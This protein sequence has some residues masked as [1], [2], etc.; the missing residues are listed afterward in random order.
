MRRN[1]KG[2]TLIELLIVVAIIGILAAIAI[3]NLLT[4]MQRSK[5]KRTMADMR[6]VATA[7]EARATDEN[8]YLVAGATSFTW[9]NGAATYS[10]LSTRL[11]P[12]YIK[13]LPQKDG[14]SRDYDFGRSNDGQQ[15][16]IRSKGKD[17]SFGAANF[18]VAG[19][20][21]FDCDIV[22]SNGTFVQYPEG[23]QAQ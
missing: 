8:T 13:A 10:A 12:T 14:W 21:N 22:Y 16:A 18:T 9:P 4:A 17:G 5:Q 3:P 23:V 20:T 15:Y 19:T 2:F 6:T 7:W 11:S 1:Q